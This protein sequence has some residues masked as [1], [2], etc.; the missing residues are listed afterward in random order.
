MY[1][2]IEKEG[3]EELDSYGLVQ[4]EFNGIRENE[5]VLMTW[6]YMIYSFI[7]INF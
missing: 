5:N 1:V 2:E 7:N 4:E 3:D 6:Q